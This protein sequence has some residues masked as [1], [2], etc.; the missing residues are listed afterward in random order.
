VKARDAAMAKAAVATLLVPG[1]GVQA[2][3]G[4]TALLRSLGIDPHVALGEAREARKP[5]AGPLRK[6]S[7]GGAI[8]VRTPLDNG[9][10]MALEMS[11]GEAVGLACA[12]QDAITRGRAS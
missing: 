9:G 6:D 11:P 1:L 4:A 8:V 10:V 3:Q 5:L 12:V 2:K 7:A